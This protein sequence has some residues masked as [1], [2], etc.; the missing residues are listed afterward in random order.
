MIGQVVVFD[1]HRINDLFRVGVVETPAPAILPELSELM[2]GSKVRS[3]RIGTSTVTIP[4]VAKRGH[5]VDVRESI[6]ALLSWLDVDGA[7]YLSLSDDRGKR[8][9]VVPTGVDIGDHEW[10]DV[11]T[12]TFEQVDPMLL[13]NTVSMA[14]TGFPVSF[15][16]GGDAPTRPVITCGAAAST[17]SVGRLWSMRLDGNVD[18]G[19]VLPSTAAA[20]LSIDCAERTAKVNGA[21]SMIPLEHDWLELTPGRHTISLPNGTASGVTISWVERWHR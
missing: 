11:L 13:G 18:M 6:S 14:P 12:L 20:S 4:L 2:R 8:R 7:R 10:N 19:V 17:Q 9:L 5:M 1:G 16:V 15:N 21:V 3:V